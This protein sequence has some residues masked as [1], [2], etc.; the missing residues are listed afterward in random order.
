VDGAGQVGIRNPSSFHAVP[1]QI[2]GA[3][4]QTFIERGETAIVGP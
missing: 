2:Y 1:G 4:K 3:A